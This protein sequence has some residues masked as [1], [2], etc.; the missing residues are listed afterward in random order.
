VHTLFRET[1][2]VGALELPDIS[3]L[4]PVALAVALVAAVLIFRLRWTVLRTLGV[5]AVLGLAAGLAGLPVG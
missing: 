2:K 4:R 3:T 5:C 1:T